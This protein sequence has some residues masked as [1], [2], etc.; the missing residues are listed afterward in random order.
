MRNV[1][2]QYSQPENKLT[3]ALVSAL[4]ADR[5]L[6]RP[7]LKWAGAVD[8]P[9][10]NS[11]RI[12]EQ[13]VPGEAEPGDEA[14]AEARGL[15][16]ACIYDDDGWALL[17]EAKV[18]AVPNATQLRKHVSTANR[19]GFEQPQLLL[20]YVDKAPVNLPEHTTAIEWKI[21]YK[22]FRE[23]AGHS[24]WARLLTEYMEV[25]ES[26]M[27]AQNYAIRG[28]ITMF[29]GMRFTADNPYSYTEAKRLIKLLG[30]ELQKRKD[31]ERLGVDPR[32]TRRQAI[33]GLTGDR[34]WDFLPLKAARDSKSFTDYP[35]LTMEV[36]REAP[37][38]SITIPNGVRGG[39]RTQLRSI[40]QE[41]FMDIVADIQKDVAPI[42]KRSHNAKCMIYALQRHF[43]SQRSDGEM[44]AR[45]EADLQTVVPGKRRLAKYQPEWIEAVY[46][47]VSH[48]KSNIQLGISM[49]FSYDCPIVQSGEVIDLFAD[50]WKAMLPIA[51]LA[52]DGA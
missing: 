11:L 16:D 23:R 21:L 22:W 8:I 3:H 14:D 1:F 40:G 44:N 7:F 47:I 52:I 19:H 34:V 9:P 31:L 13:Q 4:H 24:H 20:L 12:T 35:H 49:R 48:K 50:S 30:D 6:L 39:F 46:N 27:I 2:D 25:F 45:I 37:S 38:A 32:G 17:I 26:R 42:T 5:A 33:T 10:S 43:R 41:G 18:Q 51:Q 29:D 36:G 15:P 28:T